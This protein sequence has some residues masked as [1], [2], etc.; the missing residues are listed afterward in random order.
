MT[1]VILGVAIL[2]LF[3]FVFYIMNRLDIFLQDNY[4]SI[5]TKDEKEPSCVM[6][7]E[8]LSDEEIIQEIRHFQKN[9]EYTGILLYDD[10]GVTE[11][12]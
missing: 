2:V 12:N 1:E 7:A 10:P 6:L 3:V 4:K 5:T 9:H 8:G 11:E